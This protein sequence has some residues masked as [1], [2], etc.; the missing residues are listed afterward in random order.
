MHLYIVNDYKVNDGKTITFSETKKERNEKM[1][2]IIKENII[3]KNTQMIKHSM[4]ARLKS[5]YQV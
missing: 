3:N 4:K 2:E 1:T 5:F